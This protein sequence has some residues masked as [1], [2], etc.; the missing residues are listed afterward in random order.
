MRIILILLLLNGCANYR[1][2]HI[3]PDGS[4]CTLTITSMREVDAGELTVL[5]DCS[6]DSGADKLGANERLIDLFHAVVRR[7][8]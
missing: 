5:D 2:E 4:S 6:L 1:Y 8:P 3:A 7:L